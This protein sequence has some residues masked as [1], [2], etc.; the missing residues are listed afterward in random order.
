MLGTN[1]TWRCRENCHQP[2][3]LQSALKVQKDE[4]L[5]QGPVKIGI[6]M[7]FWVQRGD[8]AVEMQGSLLGEPEMRLTDGEMS[9]WDL[10]VLL[11]N[12]GNAEQGGLS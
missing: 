9:L 4:L 3:Q 12:R 8:A 7:F 2:P 5:Q 1:I 6:L 11:S 10:Q